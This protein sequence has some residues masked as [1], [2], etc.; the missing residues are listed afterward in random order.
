MKIL[1]ID[2]HALVREG[3]KQILRQI[4][5]CEEIIE[6]K[7]ATEAL[8]AVDENADLDLILVDLMLPDQDGF[9][10][11]ACL[12]EK[13]STSAVVVMSASTDI[14]D[15]ER[16]FKI[17]A[18]GYIPK[19][20]SAGITLG[21]LRLVLAGGIYLP[22]DVLVKQSQHSTRTSFVVKAVEGALVKPQELGLS[23]RQAQVLA[24][25]VQGKS[26]KSIAR[27]LQLAEQTVKAH[28]SAA[29]RALNVENRTQAAIAVTQLGL[30]FG[31]YAPSS[32]SRKI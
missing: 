8:Q 28:I 6:A 29:L 20:C 11:L 21:A 24:L 16:V 2:D 23:E 3:L 31:K 7:N 22:P 9:H 5:G 10:I 32:S 18:A 25:L 13:R 1:L 15:V 12:H 26:N 14:A 17:G 30:D 19:S 27:D 4:E